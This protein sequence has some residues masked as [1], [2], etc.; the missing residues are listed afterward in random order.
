MKSG[1]R[2]LSALE[3]PDDRMKCI[4]PPPKRPFL[5]AI[6]ALLLFSAAIGQTPSTDVG[7]KSRPLNLLVIGDSISWG[8]GLKEDHKT[9]YMVKAWLE[10]NSG[11]EVREVVEAHSGALV[12]SVGDPQSKSFTSFDG[13]LSRPYP[14]V[15]DQLDIAI[16]NYDDP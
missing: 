1:R 16:K 14:N 3:S 10:Q 9:W 6:A 12:G 13:E 8:Q 2:R 4:A 5:A 7:R 15:N 11:R